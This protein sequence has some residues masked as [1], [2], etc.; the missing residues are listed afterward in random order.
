MT[1]IKSRKHSPA[2][3]L[4]GR[5]ATATLVALGASVSGHAQTTLNEVRVEAS[6]DFKTEKSASP[7]FT[8]PLLDTPKSITVIPQEVIRQ[9]GATTLVDALRTSPGITFGAGEGGNPVGDRP[10]IRGFDSQS[11]TYVDGV[12]DGAAQTREIFNVESVEVVKGPSSVFGGRGSAGGSVNIVSKAPQAENFFSGSIGLGTDSYQRETL[13]INRKLSD[14]VAARLN[15]MNFKSDV[16]GR[17][18][19]NAK[20]WGIA[21]SVT[22][23]M[24]S[25][26]Q[27]TLSYY[28]YETNDLPDSGIPYNNPFSSGANM[29]LNGNGQPISVPRG[30]YYGVVGRDYQR[31]KVDASTIDVKH[32][33]GGGMV[34]RNVTRSSQSSNDYIWT[35]PDDSRGNFLVNGGIW[36]RPNNRVS[37]SDSLV[38]QTS[39][40]G[41]FETAGIKHTYV[42]GLELGKEATTKGNYL[43][44]QDVKTGFETYPRS[45]ITG[46]NCAVGSGVR[47]AFNCT[48]MLNPNPYDPWTGAITP[49]PAVTEVKTRTTSLYAFDTIEFNPQWS[50]NLGLRWDD[51]KTKAVTPAY[52]TPIAVTAA[53][54]SAAASGSTSLAV[55]PGGVVPGIELEN[56]ASFLNYQAGLVYKPAPNGSIYV[57]YGT[58]STPPGTDGGD[59]A[60]GISA[61]IRNLK[62]QESRSFELGTKW[63]V[64]DRRLVLTSAIFRTDMKNARTTAADGTTQNVGKKRVQG[65]E[66]GAAGSI[67]R[68]WQ[69]FG[70]YTYLD[71]KLTDNGFALTNGVYSPSPFNG[72]AFPNTPRNSA[73]LWTTYTVMPGLT[74]GGGA[75]YVGKQYGNVNNTKWIPS[76]VKYDAMVSYTV[77]KNFSLQLN[78]QNLTNKY[79]FDKAYASHYATVGA[80]RSASLTGTFSF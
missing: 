58:S 8:A 74:I 79:Y 52:A 37:D 64:L 76:Y 30:T 31:T 17:G 19:V 45:A 61:A 75:T 57:S 67:T 20:R 48:T 27:V 39:L 24:N 21:P 11:D 73:T 18:P 60:D 63:E 50:L 4:S 6:T 65:V 28:H 42:A 70:G 22:F 47:S 68:D 5:A 26:T 38:N 69:V 36:R 66:F 40:S 13:D 9:T 15:A 51:Y 35:Q 56:K 16:A 7:K 46:T 77:N 55:R 78:V 41:K 34:L 10:F 12:R 32:D 33:F 2:R 49:S 72:N 29:A 44:L 62:P 71:A 43:F 23:G 59:G 53:V 14:S 80:G 1:H 54:P 25:P 3:Y